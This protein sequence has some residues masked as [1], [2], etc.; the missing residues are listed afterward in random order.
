MTKLGR[1]ALI[2]MAVV[3]LAGVPLA[4]GQCIS[5]TT[6]GSAYTQNFDTLS[7]V[8]GSTT[9]NLTIPGWFM[10]EGGGGARDNEQYAVDTGGSTTGDTY[11]YGAAG[12]TE[13]ALGQ[14]RSG[15][16][17]P[18]FGACF[19]NNTGAT[20][21]SLA[22]AY[23]GEEWRLGT[24]ARTDQMNFEYS[25]NATDLVTG[26]W[27]NVAALNFVTPDT[28]TTGA[29]NGNA[30]ADRTALS[31]TINSLTIANGATFWIR[32]ND[33][34][35]TGA[36]D[37]LAVDDFSLTP[38]A[39]VALPNLSVNDV[40][41]NEG[42]AGTTSFTFT[43]SLSAPAGPGGV[44]FDI[45]TAD[46][47]ATQ[48]SDYTQK[49]LTAQTIPAGSSTYS[50]TVLVNG[51]TTPE[52]NETFFVNVTNV[53]GAGITDGQGQGTIVNDDAAPNLTINDVTL[54]EGNAGTTTFTFT[55]SLSSP[56]P[57]G[58]TTF[59]IAT[60]NNTATAPS[61]YTAKSLTSQTIPAGSSTYTF[62]VLVNGDTTPE[63][64]ETFF[65]NVTNVTNAIVTDGQGLGTITN[66]DF[67][68]IHDIQGNGDTSPLVGQSIITRGIVT[69]VK[70][71]GYFIEAPDAEWDADPNTSEGVFV[72]TS[73]A[74]PA[75]AAVGNLVSV[76]ATIQE[77]IPSA[78]PFSPSATELISPTTTLLSTGNPLP[79]AITLTT[80]DTNPAGTLTE[81]EK[82]EGMRVHVNTL[83]VVGPTQG[84]VNEANATSTSNGVFYGVL[85]G[86]N[87]PFREP[88]IQANDPIPNPPCCIP[89]FDFNPERLRVD[90]DAIGGTAIDVT[91]GATVTNI[92]GP[93]DYG[94]RTYTIDPEPATVPGVSGNVTFT[95]V[96]SPLATEFTV[97]CQNL[98]RFFDDVPDGNGAVTLTTTAYNNRKNKASL[99][100]RNVLH[101]PDI[102][103]V[104]EAET[105]TGLQSL[106]AKVNADAVTAGQPNPNYT[107]YLQNGNDIGGINVG[108]LVNSTRV[109]VN[110]VNQAPGSLTATYTDPTSGNQAL[111]WDR[112]PLVLDAT[113]IGPPAVNI[114]VIV[115]HLRSLNGV[116]DPTPNGSSTEGDRVR[117][118]RRA[119]AEWLAN[120]VQSRMTANPNERLVLVGDFNAFEFNDGYVDVMGT[121]KGNPTPSTNVLLASADLVNPN[122]INLS[123]TGPAAQQYSYNF[124]GDAQSI[125]HA[126]INTQ[127]AANFSRFAHGRV[128]ADFP[129]VYRNDSTR[130]ERLSDHDGEVIY[131]SLTPTVHFDVSIPASVTQ[132]VAFT[133]T[134]T[135][136]DAL[137][138]VVT[139]YN[140][141]VHFTSSDGGAALPSD[142]TFNGGDAGTHTFTNGFTL[143]AAGSQ[144][145]TAT[146]T[147]SPTIT[148]TANTTVTCPAITPAASNNGPICQGATLQLDATDI[149]GATYSWTGPN[150]FTAAVRNPSISNAQPAASGLYT[151]TINN[152]GCV[153][154][155]TTTAQVD[156]L[157]PT[158][159]ISAD[160]NG[161]GTS[162]Q[163]CPEQPLTL[164]ANGAPTAT[165]YQ[166]YKDGDLLPGET[167]STY[168][169][170]GAATYYVTA[171][172]GSCTTVQSAGYVVQNP[173]PHS[174][175]VSFRGQDSSV[176][177]LSICQGS[178]QIIDSDSATGIQWWKDGAPIPGANSQSYT[179]TQ[180]G[181][182]TAQL[183]ALGCHSQFGRNVTLTVDALPPTP[184]ISGDT[185]GTGT[186]DQACPEQPLT[187][188]ANGATGAESYTWYS[189]NA[190]I[191]NETSST[192]VVTGVGNYSVTA[193]NG[194]CTT[195]HSATYVVQNPT[196]HSP[197]V[198][199]RG[200][201]STTTSI[202][203]CQ[204]TSVILDSDSATGI[205][206]W[207]D[208]S[209]IPGPQTQSLTVTASGVYTA[210]LDALG[211]H[212]QFGR[213]ITVTVNPLPPTPTVTPGGP[214]TFCAGGS[215]TLTSSAGSGN[216]W[217]LNG[218]PIGGATGTSYNATASGSYTVTVTDGNGCSATSAPTSVT[219]NP[220]PPTPTVTPG[221]PTTFC[222]GGSVT[223]T[224]S[225]ASGNQWNLNGSPIGGATGNTY[226]ATASG[227]YTVTVTDG[228]NCSATSAPTTVTVNPIPET[229]SVTP[230]G[231]T[232]FC[233]GGSVTLTSSSA[234]GN[235]WYV[236][237]SPIG[238]Q[239][240]QTY[241]ATTSGDYSVVV[242]TNGCSSAASAVTTVNVNP[243][244]NATITA[245]ASVQSG[246]TG[247]V[248]SVANAGA[249][250][251]YNWS[252]TN[253]TI[254][255]GT[256]TNSV[257][258]TAG[259]VGTLTLQ[260][261]VTT[262]AGC[263]D[264]KSAN[265]NVTAIPT[266]LTVTSV[267]PPAGKTTGGKAVTVH[268]TGFVSGATLT[269]GGA[270][271][272]NVV[273]VNS[274]T[275][276]AK[277]PAH[278][279]GAVNVT[280]TNPSSQ[281]ATLTNGYTYV[282]QQFDA[283]GDN[284][285]DPADIFYLVNYLFLNGNP[286]AGAT[287]MD[288]G[289]ANGDGTVDPSDIFYVIN[290]LYTHGP[291]P[292][293]APPRLASQSVR[294][295][296]AGDVTLGE[297]VRRGDKFVIP[298]SVNVAPGA[299]APEALAL[300]VTFSGGTARNAVIRRAG[301][302]RALQP[303]FEISRTAPNALAY[304]VSFNAPLHGVVAEI[305]VEASAG[306]AIGID[307]AVTV[308]SNAAGTRE[309]TVAAGTLRV[310][311]TAIDAVAR[312]E[313]K[314]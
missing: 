95:A 65:V 197:F 45:A 12:S 235:Q 157:P 121:I 102:L 240:G 277:T 24:A 35:A 170:T 21:N 303:S 281:S 148:G 200:Q 133:G 312:P 211:C 160:T 113:V 298:V 54:A 118:K 3:A 81:M 247:N 275:I 236:N 85:P 103:G 199:I 80:A 257:T 173:T 201:A 11:S 101:A 186:Q 246:S 87:R 304:L 13:R 222:T 158:P 255:G 283:N 219:V 248:A 250:A 292:A 214:T 115:N 25:L 309:A 106:A 73:S 180:A 43:V 61:D 57:A 19:T 218:S 185:N 92:T 314:E 311:G 147:L 258:F 271:A 84:T 140:G 62:D 130:P 223:L 167:S 31:S 183:N 20:I 110:S 284:V 151:V 124:D 212:S 273:V 198:S 63:P 82:Y 88:G 202:A 90:S 239:T 188:H 207:K 310:N 261:T 50:F 47:T 178:S 119:G 125:D 86:I 78:D 22:V 27:T 6:L 299:E 96:P 221:G 108:F 269:F 38:Q 109:T 204:G 32:W 4:H 208:G 155:P 161:T 297:P 52:V 215:V 91:A 251:T 162:D 245:P 7:N 79:T 182:Y 15:T 114:V 237:G 40:S 168:Q 75:A 132:G 105:L 270:A 265:V 220:L 141:T 302:T 154:N 176:T 209:P 56:A 134:V 254:T 98:E 153:Y 278:A 196:P 64:N 244:P 192:L 288:S 205:Q 17:I 172:N 249:G 72:F 99:L 34:D 68:A 53:T 274:T 111:I 217:K 9:N 228:N 164:H 29:K 300:R 231:P 8:A 313:R 26:T 253:G 189:D 308:L 194:S 285:I 301:T 117:Q 305:E 70:S 286:P 165:S 163:A 282:P 213:N 2:A 145:I 14:L 226:N 234:S 156:T 77:F 177:T 58:G 36:D 135:A 76:S 46:G 296:I 266:P 224:S 59:D 291:A 238:G 5:L 120:Y 256:G 193:T 187:L 181:V 268:G 179:A 131:F 169:A 138:N 83:N 104:E 89:R 146:D 272:T 294:Q 139:G 230:G 259:G 233:N 10:T 1:I 67:T 144:S 152:A 93:M 232:T 229:P 290:Y 195:A 55:V 260:V 97:G 190:V 289:D 51:D 71:N 252:I 264:T 48:P 241:I 227:S 216:Q 74:P 243:N 39:G 123:T 150:G 276:T 142:Y 128:D 191:P 127:A 44:T 293:S 263:S 49:S 143:N 23:N 166:W 30:A 126:L 41:L 60:A 94:F 175:F 18:L 184:T 306:T 280:V 295:T 206:W 203:V 225:S 287:G 136:K 66:D 159:T 107:A 28:V 149:P 171:T 242:T 262:S 307:P 42:N 129:E 279:G 69:G 122:L 33:T 210:Q 112:P 100:I 174:P 137:N 16:L 37:G 267:T 116:D